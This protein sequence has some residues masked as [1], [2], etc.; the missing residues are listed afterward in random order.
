MQ[1]CII[2]E[3]E[4]KNNLCNDHYS[5][6]CKE[7]DIID[8]NMSF[9]DMKKYYQNL[10]NYIFRF[11][12]TKEQLQN[13]LCRLIAIAEISRDIYKN[14][15]L[16][17]KVYGEVKE[18]I[19]KKEDYILKVQSKKDEK[20]DEYF[21][22]RDFRNTFPHDIRTDDGHMVTSDPEKMIDD[23]LYKNRIIH[24]YEPIVMLKSHPKAVVSADF[25][26]PKY[27]IYVEVWGD[28]NEE[29]IKRKEIKQMY[30]KEDG[31]RVLE[32]NC[33]EVKRSEV[34]ARAFLIFG[35][36]INPNI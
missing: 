17:T 27:D 6:M 13:A 30:Y 31:I 16:Q 14:D 34:I 8:K 11:T 9:Y 1:K 19:S 3:K 22:D 28:I 25:Y 24:S 12:K 29:Y 18:I 26:L 5:Q 7:K 2:C 36:E 4:T 10:K 23:L 35:I 21:N 15:E 33:K 32:I 20:A